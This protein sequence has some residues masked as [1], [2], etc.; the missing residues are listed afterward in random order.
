MKR[1]R[2]IVCILMVG[3]CLFAGSCTPAADQKTASSA[4]ASA[5]QPESSAPD[6]SKTPSSS[7][8]KASS[9]ASQ[10]QAKP[11]KAVQ[12]K[13]WAFA[14]YDGWCYCLTFDEQMF[15]IRP[16][17][18]GKQRLAR[19]NYVSAFGFLDGQLYY[20]LSK[21]SDFSNSTLYRSDPDGE[22][23]KQV[24]KR[25]ITAL[26]SDGSY[27]YYTGETDGLYRAKAGGVQER[28]LVSGQCQVLA[29][30]KGWFYYFQQGA[31]YRIKSDGSGKKKLYGNGDLE[32]LAIL[33]SYVLLQTSSG[34]YCMNLDGTGKTELSGVDIASPASYGK[35]IYYADLDPNTQNKYIVHRLNPKTKD[36]EQVCEIPY[37]RFMILG[38]YLYYNSTRQFAYKSTTTLYRY[39]LKTGEETSIGEAE[40]SGS[41]YASMEADGR[42]FAYS[43]SRVAGEQAKLKWYVLGRGLS[44][45]DPI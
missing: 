23:L 10:T 19:G 29:F 43:V 39:N 8:A 30:Q 2:G 42:L 17:K 11:A 12:S 26:W 31:L 44:S 7:A 14:T 16:D 38:D 36:M 28:K 1:H 37:R 40:G 32:D 41:L 4:V 33:D 22:N 5:V 24:A 21:N 20:A 18:T 45:S 3:I 15:R 35:W 27:L 25:T 6:V 9:A 34:Y 13:D